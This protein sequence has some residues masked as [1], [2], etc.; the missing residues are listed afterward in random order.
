MGKSE[1][2]E[3][4]SLV[5][6][7]GC[8]APGFPPAISRFFL[9]GIRF[10]VYGVGEDND[11][12]TRGLPPITPTPWGGI[13]GRLDCLRGQTSRAGKFGMRTFSFFHG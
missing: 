10:S 4:R 1:E 5:P 11:S 6:A 9:E 7:L 8:R 13:G 2:M 12:P 3:G